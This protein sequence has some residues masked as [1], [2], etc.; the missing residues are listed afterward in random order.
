MTY[1]MELSVAS[2]SRTHT[3]KTRVLSSIASLSTRRIRSS[4]E[5]MRF[6]LK[7]FREISLKIPWRYSLRCNFHYFFLVFFFSNL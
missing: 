4:F 1:E 3:H 7:A 5:H 2:L 6:S